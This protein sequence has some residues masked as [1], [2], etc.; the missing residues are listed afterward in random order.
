V[1]AHLELVVELDMARF[2]LAKHDG[3]RHELAHARRRHERVRILLIE[4][5]IGIGIHENGVLGLGVEGACGSLGRGGCRSRETYGPRG[6]HSESHGGLD[7]H[8]KAQCVHVLLTSDRLA[9]R[10]PPH[11]PWGPTIVR[12][13]RKSNPREHEL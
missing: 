7:Q 9:R 6:K 8:I 10:R 13:T 11:R 4:D 3:K 1:L 5:E 12:S 2:Q